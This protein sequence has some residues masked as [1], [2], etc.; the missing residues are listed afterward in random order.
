MKPI[1]VENFADNGAHS[2]WSVIN[3]ETGEI[4]ITDI[5]EDL[6]GKCTCKL[7]EAFH[8]CPLYDNGTCDS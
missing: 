1:I 4:I 2:H 5:A 6:T 8:C 7:G 3:S